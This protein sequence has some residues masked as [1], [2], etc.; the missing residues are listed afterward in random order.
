MDANLVVVLKD[1]DT[2][3]QSSQ[4]IFRWACEFGIA[5]TPYRGIPKEAKVYHRR[6]NTSL[7]VLLRNDSEEP[8]LLLLVSL[9]AETG[10]QPID[11]IERMLEGM[12]PENRFF[13]RG[14]HAAELHARPVI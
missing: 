14:Y 9:M 12:L 10:G 3:C 4:G 1:G 7:G 8:E 11:V 2:A 6:S 13:C 5:H